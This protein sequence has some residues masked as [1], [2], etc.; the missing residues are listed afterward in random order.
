MVT[1]SSRPTRGEAVVLAVAM[2][3]MLLSVVAATVGGVAPMFFVT[4]VS[5]VVSA[6]PR[7]VVNM[8]HTVAQWVRRN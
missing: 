2:S 6:A 5:A 4:M 8:V 3:M 1:L 7:N